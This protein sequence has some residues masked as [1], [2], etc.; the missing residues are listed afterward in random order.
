[1]AGAAA[2]ATFVV[3]DGRSRRWEGFLLVGVYGLA[4]VAYALV[5][6]SLGDE[7]LL[8]ARERVA[9][10]DEPL[11]VDAQPLAALAAAGGDPAVGVALERRLAPA[12]Q[13]ADDLR[14]QRAVLPPEDELVPLRPPAAE[15]RAYLGRRLGLGA[16]GSIA[17]GRSSAA[18]AASEI[19]NSSMSPR[20][21]E[22]VSEAAPVCPCGR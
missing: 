7:R 2:F 13:R 21:P 8:G 16:H 20:V 22:L 10:P 15:D 19:A 4:V 9:R 3:W 14:L 6:S 18:F 11:A 5:W 1:M 12:G 17:G